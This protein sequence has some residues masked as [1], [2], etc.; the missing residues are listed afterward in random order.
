M[1]FGRDRQ[2]FGSDPGREFALDP[3]ERE[4]LTPRGCAVSDSVTQEVQNLESV[5]ERLRQVYTA[6]AVLLEW[7]VES[8]GCLLSVPR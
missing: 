6:A 8:M 3:I 1:A 7:K 5:D 4:R 2:S